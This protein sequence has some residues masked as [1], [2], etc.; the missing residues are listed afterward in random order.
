MAAEFGLSIFLS[1]LLN[2]CVYLCLSSGARSIMEINNNPL[3]TVDFPSREVVCVCKL[4]FEQQYARTG[5]TNN[6]A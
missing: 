1:D 6:T 4:V 3:A 2:E 5:S